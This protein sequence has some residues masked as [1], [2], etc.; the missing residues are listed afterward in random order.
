MLSYSDD[1]DHRD[2]L[3]CSSLAE[4]MPL[5]FL[6][7]RQLKDMIIHRPSELPK[8]L[9][10]TKPIAEAVRQVGILRNMAGIVLADNEKELAEADFE[11]YG[12]RDDRSK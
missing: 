5:D 1:R 9:L 12:G 6:L 10:N 8:E 3:L 11:G 2:N 7:D 4:R